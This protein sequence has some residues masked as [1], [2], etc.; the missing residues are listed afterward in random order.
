VNRAA[1]IPAAR[2]RLILDAS[3]RRW[4]ASLRLKD[5]D[6][7]MPERV[8]G[9]T[10]THDGA[11]LLWADDRIE[12]PSERIACYRRIDTGVRSFVIALA[13]LLGAAS[14]EAAILSNAQGQV[15]LRTAEGTRVIADSSEAAQGAVVST[16]PTGSVTINYASGCFQTLGPK[17][18]GQDL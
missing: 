5:R 6:G 3:Q 15:S 10:K 14:A 9:R 1:A 8:R 13:L 2:R 18:A 7:A 12:Q 4:I 16:G 11:N 17:P